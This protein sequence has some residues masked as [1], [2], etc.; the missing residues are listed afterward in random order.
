MAPLLT[1]DRCWLRLHLLSYDWRDFIHKVFVSRGFD[2][3]VSSLF[4]HEIALFRSAEAL[5]CG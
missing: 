5:K 2:W 3:V 4:F 1:F